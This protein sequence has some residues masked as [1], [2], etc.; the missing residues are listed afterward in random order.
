MSKKLIADA[1]LHGY[2]GPVNI[3]T[4][5]FQDCLS[6]EWLNNIMIEEVSELIP[7][8]LEEEQF[9]P[10]TSDDYFW[11][12]ESRFKTANGIIVILIPWAQDWDK[13]DGSQFDRAIAVYTKGA[14]TEAEIAEVLLQFGNGIANYS[15]AK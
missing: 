4:D 6:L 7:G 12:S 10:T 15:R 1:K 8:Y 11:F 13:K 14:V 9:Q 5:Q 2:D 3:S